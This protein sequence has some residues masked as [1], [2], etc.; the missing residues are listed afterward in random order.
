LH[1]PVFNDIK[2]GVVPGGVVVYQSFALDPEAG[3]PAQDH[4]RLLRPGELR[5]IFSK[6]EILRYRELAGLSREG[7]T[8]PI[9][10]IV[11]RKPR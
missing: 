9:A 5:E 11:A 8:R 3:G 2:D 7:E 6:W 4:E 1:R 10:G